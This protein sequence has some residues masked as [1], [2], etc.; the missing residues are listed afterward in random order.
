MQSKLPRYLFLSLFLVGILLIVYI[1]FTSGKSIDRL[2]DGNNE[3]LSQLGFENSL[4]QLQTDIAN[5]ENNIRGAIITLDN[6]HIQDISKEINYVNTDLA[7]IKKNM[8]VAVDTLQVQQLE[9]LVNKKIDFINQVLGVFNTKG[10]PDAEIL[11]NTE[12]GKQL[13]EDIFLLIDT[14]DDKRQQELSRITAYINNNA[15]SAHTSG[16]ILAAIAAMSCI[17]A[18][19]YIV[20]QTY[21]QK[22]LIRELDISE[23]KAREAAHIKENFLANMSHEIRTPLNAI[24]G[25]T[26]LL[27]KTKLD[28]GQKT[29][30][31][32]IKT[33]GESLLDIV[34]DIL[35]LSKL[36]AGML[37]IENSPFTLHKVLDSVEALF[38]PKADE[39]NLFLGV[40]ID[41]SVPDDLLG[42]EMRLTQILVNLTGNAIKFTN[43]GSVTIAVSGKEINDDKIMLEITIK[44]TGIGIP[45][46]KQQ[47]IFERFEQAENET[48]R[49]Y[50]GSGL[51][52][53]IVKQLLQ[54]QGG[55]IKVISEPGK[56]SEFTASIPYTINKQS[57]ED[58]LASLTQKQVNGFAESKNVLVAEDNVMNQM[59]LRHLFQQWNL[60]TYTV[61]NGAEV[62]SELKRNKYDLVIMDIQMPEMDGYV[63]TEKIRH[64]LNSSIP[65]IAMTAHA[66]AGER[67]KCINAGM[68]DYISKPV[69]EEELY[70]LMQKYIL[71]DGS[72]TTP[73]IDMAYLDD[74]SHNN[75]SF[76]KEMVEQFLQQAPGE[77]EQLKE[78]IK[79]RNVAAIRSSGHA[80]KTSVS[81]MGL[82]PVLEE[83]LLFFEN[84]QPSQLPNN[85]PSWRLLAITSILEKAFEDAMRM[86]YHEAL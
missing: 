33:S 44:D 43:E 53:S 26:Y 7:E 34:N 4:Q 55:D 27:D 30:L 14:F 65:V 71:H 9:V 47:R 54:L 80:M 25:F 57:R 74:I 8:P 2:I 22:K 17:S 64:E 85:E 67:E 78:A 1:Q 36:E 84:I 13:T 29:F 82:L 41:K 5:A 32:S 69:R 52:L 21:Q 61:N 70:A 79:Q 56:G 35:D 45:L 31:A 19:W 48:N 66:I 77:L 76:K 51:G 42:D 24:L 38:K 40:E 62:V 16:L 28:E 81:F 6:R 83:D 37:R 86:K 68:N 59:L 73:V 12:G 20:N 3:L 15:K 39:K 11:I 60:K 46:K 50:G 58:A 49:K 63:A 23:K 75:L 10:K 72:I 18:F